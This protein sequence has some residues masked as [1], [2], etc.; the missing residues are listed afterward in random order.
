L[1]DPAFLEVL[2]RR[3]EGD[4]DHVVSRAYRS[5]THKVCAQRRGRKTMG[6]ACLPDR[7]RFLVA[8]EGDEAGVH[9]QEEL[10]G[11]G[12]WT[13]DEPFGG[14][15]A[16]RLRDMIL[17][18]I[19]ELH[20]DRDHLDR[21]LEASRA[22]AR[23]LLNLR[24]LNAPIAIGLGGGHYVPRHTDVAL[25]RRIAFGHLL[26]TYALAKASPGLLE[27]A[28]ERTEGATLAYL[29]R[30]ALS[31]PEVRDIEQPLERLGLRIVREA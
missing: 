4:R 20:L 28:V 5:A 14:R 6:P 21:D 17:V 1:L 7:M 22:I 29:H 11:L 18:T 12:S 10:L 2:D 16:W 13:R 25:R 3:E 31:K 19:P 26:A 23:V 30:K 15:A 27:Q 8:S 24:P 9:Q